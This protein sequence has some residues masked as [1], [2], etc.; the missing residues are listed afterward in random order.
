MPVQHYPKGATNQSGEKVGGQFMPTDFSAPIYTKNT[1]PIRIDVPEEIT[2]MVKE[3]NAKGFECYVVGG[4]VRDALSGKHP[5][6]YDLTTSASV[7]EMKAAFPDWQSNNGEAHGTLLLPVFDGQKRTFLEVTTYRKDVETDGRHAVT[8]HVNDLREDLIR[9]DFTMNALAWNPVTGEIVGTGA[10]GDPSQNLSDIRNGVIRFVGDADSRIHEDSLRVMRGVR[11]FAK[12]DKMVLP[13]ETLA[14]LRRGV[15]ELLAR[16]KDGTVSMERI[17]GELRK[18]FSDYKQPSRLIRAMEAVGLLKPIMPE[19]DATRDVQQN[20]YHGNYDVY[21]HTLNVLD[22]IPH[23]APHLEALRWAALFHDTGKVE[24]QKP[25]D[26]EGYGYTFFNHESYS[27]NHLLKRLPELKL[28]NDVRDLAARIIQ[29]HMNIPRPEMSDAAIRRFLRRVNDNHDDYRD[30][31]MFRR[32]D[33]TAKPKEQN[34]SE[35][36]DYVTFENRVKTIAEQAPPVR[37]NINFG[38][39]APQLNLVGPEI[40]HAERKVKEAL[41]NGLLSNEPSAIIQYISTLNRAEFPPRQRPK[42]K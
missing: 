17:G 32:A 19:V 7:D 3:L 34:I 16:I 27:K 12:S 39:I 1:M 14:A 18:A 31:L 42:K 13:P 9:R 21:N 23:D 38:E 11:F 26:K 40:G 33:A 30:Y 6:D 8:Q 37:P 24:T 15:P 2:N 36:Y 41:D 4:A 35:P 25:S 5:H 10:N 29:E 22:R 20:V 28:T